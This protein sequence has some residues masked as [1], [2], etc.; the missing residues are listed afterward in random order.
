[1]SFVEHKLA[2]RLVDHDQS[3]ADRLPHG[4]ALSELMAHYR[5]MLDSTIIMYFLISAQ[6]HFHIF[7]Y[8]NLN[9]AKF[10]PMLKEDISYDKFQS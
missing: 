1:M 8:N 10:Y 3:Q 4:A 6:N 2:F 5:Q 7:L 9:N